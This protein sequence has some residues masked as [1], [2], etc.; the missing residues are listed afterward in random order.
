MGSS[1][2]LIF[3]QVFCPQMSLERQSVKG[4]LKTD[5]EDKGQ[6]LEARKVKAIGE[7]LVY[8]YRIFVVSFIQWNENCSGNWSGWN[9]CK[10]NR[11][12]GKEW[13]ETEGRDADQPCE[14]VT[15]QLWPTFP[16]I[17]QILI[18]EDVDTPR[19][20]TEYF[21]SSYKSWKVAWDHR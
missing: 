20:D 1:T 9:L 4:T 6:R 3:C 7:C 15:H 8:V 10:R 5:T 17:W 13:N 11:L 19:R 2:I 12:G 21:F 14:M 16:N 18:T